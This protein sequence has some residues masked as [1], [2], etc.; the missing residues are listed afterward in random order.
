MLQSMDK[1]PS[2]DKDAMQDRYIPG[3]KISD[4]YAAF[5]L[6]NSSPRRNTGAGHGNQSRNQLPSDANEI[7]GRFQVAASMD[8]MMV[9]Y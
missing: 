5:L 9:P 7:R 1:D 3:A 2:L 6:G 8:A 4:I